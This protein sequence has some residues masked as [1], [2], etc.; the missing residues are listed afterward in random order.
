LALGRL[1]AHDFAAVE[2]LLADV[3]GP[4][5]A[6]P[7]TTLDAVVA[8]RA[9]V[10]TEYQDRAYAERYVR[11]VHRVRDVERQR[12]LTGLADAV[13]QGY[14]KL[15]AYKDEYEVARL[16]SS[17]AFLEQLERT[18]EGDYRLRF[19]LAPPLL[20][21]PDSRTGQ[22]RKHEYGAWMLPVFRLLARMKGLRGTR[23]DPFGWLPDRKLERQLIADY[24]RLID[25]CLARLRPD[26]HAVA[27][28]LASLPAQVRGYGHVKRRHLEAVRA[29]E[30]ELLAQLRSDAGVAQAA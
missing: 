29:R 19:H 22:V 25:E 3:Q 23:L 24:E 13:A 21:R 5:V 8:R 14:F 26:N 9:D 7:A 27:V 1:A 4:A 17:P 15:L 11:L 6:V 10:L 28:E 30:R 12:G 16:H 20:T 2:R 18:F